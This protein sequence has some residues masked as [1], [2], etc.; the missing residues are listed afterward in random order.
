MYD[1]TGIVHGTFQKVSYM[2]QWVVFMTQ[3]TSMIKITTF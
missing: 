2:Y 1:I 3:E